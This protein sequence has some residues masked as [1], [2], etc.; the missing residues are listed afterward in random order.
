MLHFCEF[1]LK[2]G[3][4]NNGEIEKYLLNLPSTQDMIKAVLHLLKNS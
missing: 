3:D 1:K 2:K 4:T